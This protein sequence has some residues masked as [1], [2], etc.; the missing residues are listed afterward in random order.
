M[1]FPSKRFEQRADD[2]TAQMDQQVTARI[3]ALLEPRN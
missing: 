1:V 2:Q 3:K